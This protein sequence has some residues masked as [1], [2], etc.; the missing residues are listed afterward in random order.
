MEKFEVKIGGKRAQ[1]TDIQIDYMNALL[2][3]DRESAAKA[4]GASVRTVDYHVTGASG[5]LAKFRAASLNQLRTTLLLEDPCYRD[6]CRQRGR[7]LFDLPQEVSLTPSQFETANMLFTGHPDGGIGKLLRITASTI[8]F[9][10]CDLK[11]AVIP[12]GLSN[13]FD[14][15]CALLNYGFPFINGKTIG[16]SGTINLKSKDGWKVFLEQPPCHSSRHSLFLD[17]QGTLE[18]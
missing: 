18:P 16:S 11:K 2:V 3:G 4:L 5:F 9:H 13:R 8:N 12:E 1:L 14:L 10:L 7:A 15:I 6:E 17:P